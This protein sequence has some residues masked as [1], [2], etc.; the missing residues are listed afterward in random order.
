MTWKVGDSVVLKGLRGPDM[1]IIR[2]FPEDG[3]Y[4]AGQVVVG[5][6]DTQNR[7]CDWVGSAELFEAAP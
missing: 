4:Y 6:F 5:W 7:F 3:G 1:V 2:V